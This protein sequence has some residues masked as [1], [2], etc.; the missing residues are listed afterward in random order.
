[1][2]PW[3]IVQWWIWLGAECTH[4]RRLR[5]CLLPEFLFCLSITLLRKK[6]TLSEYLSQCEDE[7]LI[8]PAW[9][10]LEAR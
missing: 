2:E 5:H 8:F 1:V 4:P 6:S 3:V 10:A 9:V 7:L